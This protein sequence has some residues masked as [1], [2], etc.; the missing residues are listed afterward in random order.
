MLRIQLDIS[1][2]KS[3]GPDEIYSFIIKGC[4]EIVT[5]LL[6]YILNHSLLKGK[7]PS[8]WKQAAAVLI[9]KESTEVWCLITDLLQF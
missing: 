5:R 9:F 7:F 6:N 8:P 3:V 2:C 1:V 4:S